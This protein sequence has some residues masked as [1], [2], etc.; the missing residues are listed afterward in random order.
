MPIDGTPNDETLNGTSGDDIING[1]DGDD[2]LRGNAGADALFG[3]NDNDS[4][5]GGDG[6]D[7]LDGGNGDDALTADEFDTLDGGAGEDIAIID[8]SGLVGDVTMALDFTA[9]VVNTFAG[10]TSFVNCEMLSLTTGVGD[11]TI[12]YDSSAI[13]GDSSRTPFWHAGEGDDLVVV[14]WSDLRFAITGGTGSIAYGSSSISLTGVD[15]FHYTGGSGNDTLTGGANADVLAGSGGNDSLTGGDGADALTG[16]DGNDTLSAGNGA[17]NAGKDNANGGDGDDTINAAFKDKIDG[18]N[19]R[20]VLNLD[21]SDRTEA[22]KLKFDP[23]VNNK[24]LGTTFKNIENLNLDTGSGDDQLT[25]DSN[26]I[27]LAPGSDG[28]WDGN[29][30]TD[31]LTVNF[32]DES[33]SVTVSTSSVAIADFSFGISDIEIVDITTGSGDDSVTG[34]DGA[35]TISTNA[36]S[37]TVTA[38]AG[39]DIVNGGD[40]RDTLRGGIDNDT[41]NGGSDRD[42]LLGEDGNDTLTGG[43]GAG[44]DTLTGGIGDDLLT[45]GAGNDRLQGDAGRDTLDGGADADLMWYASIADSTGPL[46]DTVVSF[47]FS[48]DRFHFFGGVTGMDAAV[49][50]GTLSDA[51]FDADLT[52]AMTALGSR[53]AVL[54]TP[55]AGQYAGAVFLVVDGN[56]TAGFQANADYVVHLLTPVNIDQA[57]VTDF[58]G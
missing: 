8:L 22:A 4:L 13:Y 16:G 25:I 40:G 24:V 51:T 32:A 34:R 1:F 54:F 44:R 7:T 48:M 19:G 55:D 42:S 52:N 39:D 29:L 49:T 11:D 43:S 9:G 14:D 38:G 28:S 5:D 27:Q 56:G 35:D 12:T 58:Q 57:D 23:L 37:D 10:A 41:L 30:G 26:A 33:L 50:T 15:R 47:D 6:A 2:T 31:T 18:G 46:I 20:D 3:G 36:G 17:D 45:G 53:H 21:L